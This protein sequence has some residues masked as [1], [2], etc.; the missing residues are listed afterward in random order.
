[1]TLYD[2]SSLAGWTLSSPSGVT[3][4]LSTSSDPSFN[5]RGG[6][7]AR[8]EYPAA[9]VGKTEVHFDVRI[10]SGNNGLVNFA[11]F[12][13]DAGVGT[14]VH[15]DTRA[16][17][18]SGLEKLNSWTSWDGYL[19]QFVN[20]EK[21]VP[22]QVWYRYIVRT[23]M[24]GS[25]AEM[26][27]T[28]FNFT[29]GLEI[30]CL[31]WA[32]FTPSGRWFAIHGDANITTGGNFDNVLISNLAEV[33]G[34]AKLSSGAAATQVVFIDASTYAQVAMVKPAADGTYSSNI[35]V[36]SYVVVAIG[37]NGYRPSAHLVTVA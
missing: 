10:P 23:R 20:G 36:G 24:N 27:I 33:S 17:Y 21:A 16:E 28:R 22:I 2:G 18:P 14:L 5:V 32:A 29:T 1:M 7:F 37:P 12:A 13:S 30:L 6:E 9:E 19:A 3:V 31:D 25:Q 11:V 26:R 35:F 4:D 15:L 8:I 34:V